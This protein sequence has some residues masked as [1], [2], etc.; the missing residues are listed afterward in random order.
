MWIFTEAADWFDKTRTD[1]NK[2][3]DQ[4]FQGWVDYATKHENEQSFWPALRNGMIYA[5]TGTLYALNQF[6]STVA[7]GFVDTLRIGDGVRTG[8]WGYGQDA[9]RLLSVAGAAAKPLNALVKV[10]RVG[11]ANVVAVDIAPVKP[12]CTWVTAAKALVMTGTRHFATVESLAK[13]MGLAETMVLCPKFLGDLLIVLR[14]MGASARDAGALTGP[15]EDTLTTLLKANPNSVAPFSIHWTLGADAVSEFGQIAKDTQVGHTMIAYLN[16]SGELR[17]LD[18]TGKI[19]RT[20][21]EADHAGYS[22]I[23]QALFYG[24][25]DTA[26]LM[27]YVSIVPTLQNGATLASL[28]QTGTT[29]LREPDEA[30]STDTQWLWHALGVEIRGL[31]FRTE[32]RRSVNIPVRVAAAKAQV[33]TQTFCVPLLRSSDL[34]PDAT[35]NDC[36]TL[37][38]YVVQSGDTLLAI[39]QAAYGDADRWRGI[40]ATNGIKDPTALQVGVTLIIP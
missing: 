17:I 13:A 16:I 34:A 27:D 5:G 19:F 28:I 6:T 39:A 36:T 18:R 24:R 3:L 4:T 35:A 21:A 1:N 9:L 23:S 30:L 20:L 22:G 29:L 40:A 33:K 31:P 37:R 7:S 10:G 12:I 25:T 32:L 15:V 8:G 14:T 2:V 38:T 26:L 11:L